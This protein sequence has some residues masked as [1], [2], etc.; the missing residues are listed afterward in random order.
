MPRPVRRHP[1]CSA[2]RRSTRRSA[3]LASGLLRGAQDLLLKTGE[4]VFPI[5][6]RFRFFPNGKINWTKLAAFAV[7]IARHSQDSCYRFSRASYSTACH[8]K[9]LNPSRRHRRSREVY[10]RHDYLDEAKEALLKWEQEP[11]RIRIEN[12]ESQRDAA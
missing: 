10:N 9:N 6:A 1:A 11:T 12:Y 2:Y 7:G 3:D 8:S 4:L 5:P